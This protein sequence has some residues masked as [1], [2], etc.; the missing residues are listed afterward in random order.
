MLANLLSRKSIFIEIILGLAF[1]SLFLVDS[2]PISMDWTVLSGLISYI[3]MV[4]VGFIFFKTSKLIK[5][6]GFAIFYYLIW[7]F[8]FSK[9]SLEPRISISFLISTVL[10]WRMVHAEEIANSKKFSFDVGFLLGISAFVYP[11]SLFLL[12]I[13]FFNYLYL[14]SLNLRVF[15]LFVLGFIFPILLGLEVL[16]LTD[17]MYWVVNFQKQFCIDFWKN[18]EVIAL[19]PILILII[20]AWVDHVAHSTTQD[21]NKR[22]IYFLFFLYFIN[23]LVISV[24]FAGINVNYIAILGFPIAVFLGRYTQY[25]NSKTWQEV[26]LW[27]YA[28]FMIGFYFREQIVAFY[29]DLLGNVSF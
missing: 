15:V 19:I 3:L 11:P 10:F 13:I 14:Q 27:V 24:I 4:A 18:L 28:I 12:S 20:S 1:L 22:H 8:V 23:W 26:I 2:Y 29:Q 16:F 17:Q 5:T 21:I 7:C 6:S 9:I 25:L